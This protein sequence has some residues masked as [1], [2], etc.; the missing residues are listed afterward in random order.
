MCNLLFYYKIIIFTCNGQ[1]RCCMIVRRTRT[2]RTWR[3]RRRRWRHRGRRDRGRTRNRL[4][5][6]HSTNRFVRKVLCTIFCQTRQMAVGVERPFGELGADQKK[7]RICRT[8][9]GVA[10]F[11]HTVTK[12]NCC[13]ICE[14]YICFKTNF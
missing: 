11:V 2:W 13:N 10:R 7:F 14:Q 8:V 5:R 12:K 1:Q 6:V 9:V 4:T 3:W